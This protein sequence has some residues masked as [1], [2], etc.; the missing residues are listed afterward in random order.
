MTI[1]AYSRPCNVN[2]QTNPI[3]DAIFNN[4]PLDRTLHVII[5]VSNPCL[6]NR[7][8]QLLR[9]FVYRTRR[10][11]QFV[12]LYIVELI[13]PGQQFVVTDKENSRHLQLQTETVLWHK[14]NLVNLGVERLLPADYKCFAWIDA[15]IE[16]ESST[17]A[18]DTLKILNGSRDIVQLFSHAVD[19][20]SDGT[21]IT[22]ANGFGYSYSKN[23]VYA[24]T[25]SDRWHPGYAWAMTR[26]AYEQLG[27]LYDRGILGSGDSIM[28]LSFVRSVK[29]MTNPQ[30]HSHYNQSMFQYQSNVGCLRLGYTP[31]V[32]RHHFHGT[33]E[34]R[35]YTERWTILMKHRYSPL[36]HVTYD[37]LGVL[38]PTDSFLVPFSEDILFYFEQRKEDDAA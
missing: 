33:K 15:D 8:Y 37:Q 11:E 30:F 22:I 32:I 19:M 35:R 36:Q 12:T 28:A 5:V 20:Q 17:W 26:R 3:K 1:T 21:N 9:D 25:G 23:K 38:V 18:L 4:E 13:Y 6:Y 31:G 16:F 27:G 10:E 29:M 2:Y 24:A 34:N 14:E 7:R